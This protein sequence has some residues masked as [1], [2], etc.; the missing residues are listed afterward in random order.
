LLVSTVFGALLHEIAH[1]RAA[2]NKGYAMQTIRLTPFG[3]TIGGGENISKDDNFLIALAG[4]LCNIVLAAFT[5]ALWWLFPATYPYTS[6]F[7]NAN[8]AIAF[9]NILPLYP[10]DGSRMVLSLTKKPMR[11]LKIMRFLGILVSII[12]AFLFVV[13]AFF[14]IHYSLGVVAIMLFIASTDGIKKEGYKHIALNAPL[15]KDHSHPIKLKTMI[16]DV[17]MQL[18]RLLRQVKKDEII[19]F[20]VV[21]KNFKKLTEITEE[22]LGEMCLEF[23]LRTT[24]NECLKGKLT[25][26]IN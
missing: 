2:Y 16:V 8:L 9:F 25:K 19:T 18:I 23:G 13:S 7:F 4:P 24:L 22:K 14:Q 15:L 3:A 17:N 12:V 5:T 10:L 1:A 26:V 20:Q 11:A 21:D 6:Y